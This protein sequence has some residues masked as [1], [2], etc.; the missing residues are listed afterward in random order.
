MNLPVATNYVSDFS[1]VLSA[2]QL[3]ELNTLAQEYENKTSH[4]LFVALFPHRNGYE[5][6]DIGMKIFGDNRIGQKG[7]DNGLLLVIATEEKKIRI[8]VGY[9]LE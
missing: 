4:Q 2:D 6:F 8:I 3:H 9:G 7:K 5:L 1:N